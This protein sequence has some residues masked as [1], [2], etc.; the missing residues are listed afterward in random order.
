MNEFRE[1][2]QD[3]ERTEIMW[4]GML[5]GNKNI[6]SSK[7]ILILTEHII[8]SFKSMKGYHVEEGL[9]VSV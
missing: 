9:D 7:E 8:A 5:E 4:G 2:L 1:E 3:E 6:W